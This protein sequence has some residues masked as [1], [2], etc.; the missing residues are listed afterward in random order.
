MSFRVICFILISLFASIGCKRTVESP[1]YIVS[2]DDNSAQNGLKKSNTDQLGDLNANGTSDGGGGDIDTS[3]PEQIK[4]A[5]FYARELILDDRFWLRLQHRP[6]F[7]F[8]TLVL[9]RD[10]RQRIRIFE[11]IQT[12]QNTSTAEAL[13]INFINKQ[14]K[15]RLEEINKPK[16]DHRDV[17][18]LKQAI[19]EI[20]LTYMDENGVLLMG[21]PIPKE[22]SDDEYKKFVSDL[23]FLQSQLPKS[24]STYIPHIK[25]RFEEAAP[26][27]ASNSTH[28]D[29]SVSEYSFNATIC[30]SLKTLQRIP[31][32]N[33]ASHV[34]GLWIHEL[35]H[36]TGYKKED[37]P[38]IFEQVAAQSHASFTSGLWKSAQSDVIKLAEEAAA[39]FG[40]ANE[41][42]NAEQLRIS[43]LKDT[44]SQTSKLTEIASLLSYSHAKLDSFHE[45]IQQAQKNEHY[46]GLPADE[47]AYLL[48]RDRKVI[49]VAKKILNSSDFYFPTQNWELIFTDHGIQQ[50][51]EIEEQYLWIVDQFKR[52][53]P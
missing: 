50:L 7:F 46:V 14:L 37:W 51:N 27:P 29:A 12:N 41:M 10:I 25:I 8:D 16:T 52:E 2:H 21:E 34:F 49:E 53:K 26:C 23:I 5:V 31:P 3:S 43:D 17:L 4:D 44:E 48:S 6:M 20:E 24:R 30:F 42:I 18:K 38:E 47:A 32:S 40:M 15:T 13:Q 11:A 1:V 39:I 9:S 33:L 28:A 45:L 22:Y 19:K 35:Y 36:M